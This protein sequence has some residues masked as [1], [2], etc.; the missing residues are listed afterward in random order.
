MFGWRAA[1]VVGRDLPWPADEAGGV[2]QR[3]MHDLAGQGVVVGV[4]PL[5]LNRRNG[6]HVAVEVSVDPV[7]SPDGRI[8]GTCSIHRDVMQRGTVAADPGTHSPQEIDLTAETE[9]DAAAATFDGLCAEHALTS[10]E[11][12]LVAL[13]LTGHRISAMARTLGRSQGTIRN[14][15]SVVYRKFDVHGQAELLD[16]LH[17]RL[18]P[19]L[20]MSA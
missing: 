9:R 14:R 8:I 4:V 5:D 1:D 13:L 6:T 10:F 16:V 18:G 7:R 2:L 3:Q 12:D 15:L 11:R 20:T 17:D 19:V